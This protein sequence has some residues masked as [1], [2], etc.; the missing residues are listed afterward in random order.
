MNVVFY[1]FHFSPNLKTQILILFSEQN[2]A[3]EYSH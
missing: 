1:F 2:M 3:Q